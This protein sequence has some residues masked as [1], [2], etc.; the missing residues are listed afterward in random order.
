MISVFH[1]IRHIVRK[2]GLLDVTGRVIQHPDIFHIRDMYPFPHDGDIYSI[3]SYGFHYLEVDRR[4]RL[5]LHPV[6]AFLGFEAS[7]RSPVD[8]QDFISASESVFPCRRPVIRF[9]DDDIAVFFLENDGAYTSVS[10][11]KH[12][13]QV[14]IFLFRNINGVRVEVFEH[15]IYPCTHYPVYRQAVYIRPVQFFQYGA[16]DFSPLSEFETL[17]LSV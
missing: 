11:G 1:G 12:H 9:V 4:A 6:A 16:F 2:S 10:L 7:G 17:A 8:A 3:S 14:F 13:L 5:A 15:R